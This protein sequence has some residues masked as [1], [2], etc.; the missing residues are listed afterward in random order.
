MQWFLFR[1]VEGAIGVCRGL[2]SFPLFPKL[3]DKVG[4]GGSSSTSSSNAVWSWPLLPLQR[5]L[6]ASYRL[7]ARLS[8]LSQGKLLKRFF[9]SHSTQWH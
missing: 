2:G 8:V 5:Q 9:E 4:G 3:P 7:R 1:A 6:A